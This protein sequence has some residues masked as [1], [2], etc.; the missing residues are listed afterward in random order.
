[1]SAALAALMASYAPVQVL[2][3]G[4]ARERPASTMRAHIAPNVLVAQNASGRAEEPSLR[5]ARQKAETQQRRAQA[6]EEMR[7]FSAAAAQEARAAQA[8][9]EADAIF[10][11]E[12]AQLQ[13]ALAKG[14]TLRL[15][16]AELKAEAAK[17]SPALDAALTRT[18]PRLESTQAKEPFAPDK[19]R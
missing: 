9:R 13:R 6:L 2:A 19:A 12:K 8:K 10:G 15:S 16:E 7:R 18:P 5:L 3:Q 11:H 1:L 17:V 4:P 14:R